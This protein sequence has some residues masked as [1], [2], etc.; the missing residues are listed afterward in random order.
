MNNTWTLAKL[1]LK[2]ANPLWGSKRGSGTKNILLLCAI[3]L[4]FLPMIGAAVMFI[5]GLFDGLKLI[6][7]EGALLAFGL[8]LSSLGIFVLGIV[9]VVTVFYYSQDV[10]HLLPLPLAPREILGAKFLVAILYEYIAE[11]IILL[12]LLVTYGVKSG[13]GVLYYLYALLV[14]LVLPV[15]PLTL[16]A[17]IVMVFMRYTNIGKSKD[18]F[19]L[20]GGLLGLVIV[21]GFQAILQG[22][23]SQ[24]ESIEHVQQLIISGNNTLINVVSQLFP[25][26]KWASLAMI[27]S[28]AF[29]GLGFL[30]S[31]LLI[32]IVGVVVF[33]LAGDRL[34]FAGVMGISESVAKRKKVDDSHFFKLVKSRPA[35]LAYAAKEWK[36]LWRTPAY[37]LN[38]VLSS[39]FLPIIGLI[40][41]LSRKD[42]GEMLASLGASVQGGNAGGIS[43]GI[44]FAIFLMLSAMNSTSVT[45]ITRDGQGFFLNKTLPMEPAHILL[46]K[47]VPGVLLSMIGILLVTIEAVWLL[48]LSPLFVA[49]ALCVGLMG[50]VYINILGLIVDLHMPKLSWGSEQEAV[51]QN[52]NPLLPLL[53]AMLTAG[54]T[55]LF[56]FWLHGT[57]VEMALV[58]FFLFGAIDFIL[59]RVLVTK[60]AQWMEKIES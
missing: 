34:Y 29:S 54:L 40:P 3:G 48:H 26:S 53:F 50:A 21:I 22:Q 60:G 43:L 5:S 12:P 45:A 31:F 39:F 1:M 37:L 41:L 16:A 55:V 56:A 25:T 33:L 46:A 42:S 28:S 47:L 2:S 23:S 59:Y 58:L 49:L 24:M 35:W 20:I 4:G 44:T 30:L 13:G 38:C 6:G 57:I 11:L 36:L 17:L 9:Y 52:F 27:N 18:R 8:A 15:I 51:K 10:E 14:F 7:Q 19:R 32:A